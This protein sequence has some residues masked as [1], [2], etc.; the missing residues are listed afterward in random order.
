VVGAL[1]CLLRLVDENITPPTTIRLIVFRCEEGA[2][3]GLPCLGSRALFGKLMPSDLLRTHRTSKLPLKENMQ[4]CGID[5]SIIERNEKLL[6]SASFESFVE[7]HIEQGSVLDKLQVPVGVVT[8][9][10]GCRRIEAEIFGHT[11]HSG[12]QAREDRHDAVFAFAEFTQR[13]DKQWE[14]WL[15]T[16]REYMTMTIGKVHTEESMEAFTRVP[17]KVCFESTKMRFDFRS[18]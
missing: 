9:I 7:L 5:T 17:D 13:C 1:V 2:C 3:Y 15:Q 6:D 8:K 16:K 4:A 14:L 10:I 12:A 18:E 11:G